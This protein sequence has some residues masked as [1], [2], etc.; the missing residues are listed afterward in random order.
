MKLLLVGDLITDVYYYC[1]SPRLCPEAPVPVLVRQ[2]QET[3]RGGAGLVEANLISLGLDVDSV[4]G[5]E[6]EKLRLFS[7]SHLVCR[8]DDDSKDVLPAVDICRDIR[9]KLPHVD[10]V[11]VSDYCKGAVSFSVAK[12]LV[13]SGKTCFVDTKNSHIEWFRGSNVTLFPNRQEYAHVKGREHLFGRVVAKLGHEGCKVYDAEHNGTLYRAAQRNVSDC[14]GA[15]DCFLAAYVWGWV[16]GLDVGECA[17]IAN[18]GAGRSV[19]ELGTYMLK[20]EDLR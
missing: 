1:V 5:S 20:V 7:G 13:L 18:D 8:L 6:S 11:V 14:T 9:Q 17:R 3:K 15:G 4:F 2:R 10:A 12:E 19:E 16:R